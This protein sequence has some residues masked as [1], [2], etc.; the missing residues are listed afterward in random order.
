MKP[1]GAAARSAS[2]RRARPTPSAPSSSPRRSCG[3]E[4]VV[5]SRH[6]ARRPVGR[7]AAASRDPPP[8]GSARPRPRRYR[9]R[10]SRP[11][12]SCRSPRRRR[13]ES[14]VGRGACGGPRAIARVEA[15]AE[16]G[17]EHPT[18]A[19]S[20][21][22]EY[23]PVLGR[24]TRRAAIRPKASCPSTP[25]PPARRASGDASATSIEASEHRFPNWFLTTS[26]ELLAHLPDGSPSAEALRAAHGQSETARSRCRSSSSTGR[27]PR[28]TRTCIATWC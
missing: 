1:A 16:P 2:S 11:G 20:L 27:E 24:C 12:C 25:I 26:L 22:I 15:R 4:P 17:P 8:A 14:A 18:Y 21:C 13:A 19:F 7:T 9:E 28:T 10:R 3:T 6:R 5:R 23:A